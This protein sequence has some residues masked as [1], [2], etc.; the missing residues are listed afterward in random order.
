MATL[1]MT[2]IGHSGLKRSGGIIEEEFLRELKGS[3]WWRVVREMQQDAVIGGV[4]LAIELS[5]RQ[6]A[7]EI[8]AADDTPQADE[9]RLFVEECLGDM[10]SS[11][12]DTLSEI[13]TM[14]SY[15]YSY[16]E[17]VYKRRMG[18]NRDTGKASKYDDGRVGWR[19]W[20][21]RSQ[22]SLDRWDF[23]GEGGL[24]GMWQVQDYGSP[25]LIPIEKAL[26]FRTST[27][28]GNPEGKSALRSAYT[29][30]YYKRNISRIE[31]IGVERDLA[32]LPVVYMPPNYLSANATANERAL[33]AA[34]KEIVTNIRRDEQEGVIMPM[35]YDDDG[36]KLFD[37][38]LLTSGGGRQ[39][40]TDAIIAR[41]NQQIS[42]SVLADFIMMGHEKVGS[43]ALSATKSSLFK[44][45][46]DAWLQAIA[47]VI[48]T[49]AIPR[50]LR[51]NGIALEFAP[52]LC[53]GR[54]GEIT[55]ED[56]TMWIDSVAKAGGQLF[57]HLETE[58]HLRRLVGLPPLDEE[59]YQAREDERKASEQ[60]DR[61]AKARPPAFVPQ[62]DAQDDSQDDTQEAEMSTQ[63]M[64]A[65]L[66]AAQRILARG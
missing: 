35:L 47:A 18:D 49:H 33:F 48:N 25:V 6:V 53:F 29:A 26:L 54:V 15:G 59:E 60:A 7:V 36:N 8:E 5:L 64:M 66:L 12:A 1:D 14:L 58:N 57:P 45:A 19:K 22:D 11:W 24:Q 3:R 27:H 40:D 42:M 13:V 2:E 50:L 61:E 34:M 9:A 17:I 23:D 43:Y 52:K 10:S 55:L 62:G 37:L 30:W 20:A 38:Q 32:G 56:V 41:Y 51:L 65:Q 16:L 31:A 4:L 46:L 44:T 28:K 39:F 21:I 63:E